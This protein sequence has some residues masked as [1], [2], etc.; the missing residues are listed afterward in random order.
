MKSKCL[1][2]LN[3]L[4]I[5][6][7]VLAISKFLPTSHLIKAMLMIGLLTLTR[8]WT[9]LGCLDRVAT[10]WLDKFFS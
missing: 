4:L 2:I 8:K 6:L 3:S 9:I 10:R 7:L 1:R 5:A